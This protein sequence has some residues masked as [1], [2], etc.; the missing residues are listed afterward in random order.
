MSPAWLVNPCAVEDIFTERVRFRT[1][2]EVFGAFEGVIK[3][4]KAILVERDSYLLGLARYCIKSGSRW[5]D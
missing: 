1:R 2:D 3:T 5:D 4:I